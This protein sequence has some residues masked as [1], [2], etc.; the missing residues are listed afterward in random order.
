MDF[1]FRLD[2][3]LRHAHCA[4]VDRLER[5][6]VVDVAEVRHRHGRLDIGVRA[7]A[8]LDRDHLPVIARPFV[9]AHAERGLQRTRDGQEETTRPAARRSLLRH[10]G[11]G[12]AGPG[13]PSLGGIEASLTGQHA[14]AAQAQLEGDRLDGGVVGQRVARCEARVVRRGRQQVSRAEVARLQTFGPRNPL[15]RTQGALPRQQHD[16]TDRRLEARRA[17]DHDSP[18]PTAIAG[19]GRGEAV[20]DRAVVLARGS[21]VLADLTT[22]F[23]LGSGT[24]KVDR[25]R[26]VRVEDRGRF[27]STRRAHA[28]H[29]LS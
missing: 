24:G 2:G 19:Q 28:L 22:R 1:R 5:S 3:R 11:F 13:H 23:V 6:V 20:R 7:A 12:A 8:E 14:L 10:G 18:V 17:V 26:E 27:G 25:S 4:Q 29:C 16:F 15:G 9:G 21:E